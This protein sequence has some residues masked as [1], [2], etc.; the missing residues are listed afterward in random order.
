MRCDVDA[1]WAVEST[2]QETADFTVDDF[3]NLHPIA[4]DLSSIESF[5]QFFLA[6]VGGTS[7]L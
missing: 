3:F 1:M 2:A 4:I 6:S 5:L 7:T